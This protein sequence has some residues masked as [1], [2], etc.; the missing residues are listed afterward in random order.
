MSE[1]I[2]QVTPDGEIIG[3]ID[4]DQ[5]HAHYVLHAAVFIFIGGPANLSLPIQEVWLQKRSPTKKQ[6]S[7]HWTLAATGHVKFIPGEP[8]NALVERSASAELEEETGWNN[9]PLRFIAQGFL[10]LEGKEQQ[11]MFIFAGRTDSFPPN[12]E[13]GEVQE[14]RK[15]PIDGVATVLETEPVTPFAREALRLL[16]I[17][18]II[19]TASNEE[20]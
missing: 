19:P 12:L 18:G 6:Y 7:N 17:A 20:N 5:A 13:Q 16:G 15:V 2:V 14:L 9:I 3:P 8:L 1:L 4:R 11:Y 10:A